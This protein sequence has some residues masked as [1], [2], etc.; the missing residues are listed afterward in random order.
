MACFLVVQDDR[1]GEGTWESQGNT[2]R[3]FNVAEPTE[4]RM[5]VGESV[6]DAL[7]RWQPTGSVLLGIAACTSFILHLG[8][9]TQECQADV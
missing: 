8:L 4:L 3:Q 2:L 6:E 9:F 7:N 1:L 5:S